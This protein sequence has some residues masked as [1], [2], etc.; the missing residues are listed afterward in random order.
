[1]GLSEEALFEEALI[2]K[3]QAGDAS[4]FE[5][6]VGL[7]QQKIYNIAYRMTGNYH[8][9]SDA[10]Q[11]VFIRIFRSIK[12]FR[13]DCSFSTWAFR[14]AAN[15]CKDLLRNRGRFS[16]EPLNEEASDESRRTLIDQDDEGNDPET[17]YENKELGEY[18]QSLIDKLP[19]ECRLVI[20]LRE[21]AGFSYREISDILCVSLGTIKSRICRARRVLQEKIIKDMQ[22]FP[23]I[24][25]LID[26]R[27]RED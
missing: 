23:E 1:M 7:Y 12:T 3:C 15:V 5:K 22:P 6:I 21:Q 26:E 24:L 14:I 2:K 20:L 25:R 8:D 11:E 27:R 4:A 9:A 10:A 18:L 16:E 17:V 19:P 13:G